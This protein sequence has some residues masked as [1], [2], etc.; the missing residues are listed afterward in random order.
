M[1][2]EIVIHQ[3]RIIILGTVHAHRESVTLVRNTIR[4]IHPD[5]VAVELNA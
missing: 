3:N 2:E 5:Q 1:K 4:D